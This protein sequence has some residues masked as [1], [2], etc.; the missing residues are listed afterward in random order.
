MVHGNPNAFNP[1]LCFDT[2]AGRIC[3]PIGTGPTFPY[4]PARAS[5][6]ELKNWT[7][8]HSPQ[9]EISRAA[10][11]SGSNELLFVN[12]VERNQESTTKLFNL[13]CNGEILLTMGGKA[14]HAPQTENSQCAK[15]LSVFVKGYKIDYTMTISQEACTTARIIVDSN[16]SVIERTVDFL[17]AKSIAKDGEI[18]LCRVLGER[19][20]EKLE[21]FKDILILVSDYYW[22]KARE[23]MMLLPTVVKNPTE[24]G[25][26]ASFW[27]GVARAGCWGL[28]AAGGASCCVGT[29]GVGCVLCSGGFGAAGSACS[30]AW[31]WC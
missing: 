21:P 12:K 25:T 1:E 7:I 10:S 15:K 17:A 19:E 16:G 13:S 30:E 8:V 4:P 5:S 2:P 23:E 20:K 9:G 6:P 31:S 24:G 29:A 3:F 28:A 27:C 22:K 14:Y 18:G 11:Y 26:Q